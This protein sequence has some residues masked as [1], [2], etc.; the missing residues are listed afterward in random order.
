MNEIGIIL[1]KWSIF[2]IGFLLVMGIFSQTALVSE[3]RVKSFMNRWGDLLFGIFL[4]TSLISVLGL[5]MYVFG[6]EK[7]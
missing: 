3:D 2:V 1:F 7:I 4:V 5:C 6:V